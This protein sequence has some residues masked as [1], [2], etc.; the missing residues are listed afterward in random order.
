MADVFMEDRGS[1]MVKQSGLKADETDK[2]AAAVLAKGFKHKVY[3][4]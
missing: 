1:T 4:R 3:N 2:D